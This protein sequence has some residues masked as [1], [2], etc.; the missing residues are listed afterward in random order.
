MDTVIQSNI[1]HRLWSKPEW[2]DTH[3]RFHRSKTKTNTQPPVEHWN[4]GELHFPNGNPPPYYPAQGIKGGK[5]KRRIKQDWS[6]TN[7]TCFTFAREPLPKQ[8]WNPCKLRSND[9]SE[10][11][12]PVSTLNGSPACRSLM[13]NQ[14]TASSDVACQIWKGTAPTLLTSVNL[15]EKKQNYPV[16]PTNPTVNTNGFLNLPE[17]VSLWSLGLLHID[18]WIYLVLERTVLLLS[19][20]L[21]FLVVGWY[22]PQSSIVFC[23]DPR[24]CAPSVFVGSLHGMPPRP[25]FEGH[26]GHRQPPDLTTPRLAPGSE[27]RREGLLS[28]TFQHLQHLAASESTSFSPPPGLRFSVLPRHTSTCAQARHHPPWSPHLAAPG[29]SGPKK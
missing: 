19:Y 18:I 29:W 4:R 14:P 26:Y 16:N 8:P 10:T 21:V 2:W 28:G 5:K 17:M 1:G 7:Q 6:F 25:D 23:L 13:L 12:P 9:I 11:W 22:P 3:T 27:T 20:W 15:R 24:H